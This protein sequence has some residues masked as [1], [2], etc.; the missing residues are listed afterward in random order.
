ML[1]MR[2]PEGKSFSSIRAVVNLG[3]IAMF[4]RQSICQQQT[5][6]IVHRN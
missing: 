2:Y 3:N 6:G 5:F 4:W 1:P